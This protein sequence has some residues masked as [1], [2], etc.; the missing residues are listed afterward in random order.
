MG[1]LKDYD[2]KNAKSE[3]KDTFLS[4]GDGLA[5]RV[6]KTGAKT[7]VFRYRRP[8]DKKQDKLTIGTYPEMSLK[9]ARLEIAE[10]KKQL[11]QGL[12]P[13]QVKAAKYAENSQALTM[14]KVFTAWMQ[15][16]AKSKEVTPRTVKQHQSRWENH[17]KKHFTAILA[18]DL[19]RAHISMALEN[20]RH[21]GI[22]EE[23]RKALT[24][25]N[26][27]LDYAVS[28]HYVDA[29]H[30]RLL[31]PKDFK[32]SSSAPR[33]RHLSI[34]ELQEFWETLEN[35][36]DTD[37]KQIISVS[38]A[39]VA[40]FKVL[41]LTGARRSEVVEMKWSD[42]DFTKR[43]WLLATTKNKKQH[44]VFLSDF[45]IS[46][47]ED[48]K[49]LS[50]PSEYVFASLKDNNKHIT[51]DS[52]TKAVLRFRGQDKTKTQEKNNIICPLEHF[53]AFTVHDIRRSAATAWGEYLKIQPHIIEKML[54]HQPKD[55]LVAT[56]QKSE[57]R[58]E[59]KT[60]WLMWSD[61]VE[62]VIVNRQTNVV[63]ISNK[64]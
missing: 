32:S 63:H 36:L 29:N 49:P 58:E 40:A 50:G 5:L 59:Q 45:L 62:A 56:Y 20:M 22:K 47:I 53:P 18:R 12:N 31:T 52:L 6:L 23:T 14:E 60:G 57:Y 55:K 19:T 4:D 25:I 16:I 41:I 2:V 27:M 48:L 1:K 37:V 26:L 21:K 64:K 10:F 11:T 38:P 8:I 3:T 34:D 61:K 17:L 46:I 28:R 9:N 51:A 13:K 7:W 39:A 42:L 15:H 44:T 24:T 30:A 43:E 54:N 33:E 35:C